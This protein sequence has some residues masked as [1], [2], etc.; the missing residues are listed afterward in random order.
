MRAAAAV[1]RCA[2]NRKP[3]VCVDAGGAILPGAPSQCE[4][5]YVTQI[6]TPGAETTPRWFQ[7]VA[8]ERATTKADPDEAITHTGQTPSTLR[9]L[10]RSRAVRACRHSP[11]RRTFHDDP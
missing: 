9:F 10:L 7:A 1:A 2:A 3:G 4:K 6:G 8:E 5:E 11:S